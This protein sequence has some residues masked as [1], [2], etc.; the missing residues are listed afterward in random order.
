MWSIR[1]LGR[2]D[3]PWCVDDRTGEFVRTDGENPLCISKPPAMLSLH[4]MEDCI[5]WGIVFGQLREDECS[6]E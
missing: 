6:S 2:G 1:W 5:A 3:E 4:N